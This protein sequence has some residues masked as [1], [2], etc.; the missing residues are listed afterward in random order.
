MIVN[1]DLS[2]TLQFGVRLKDAQRKLVYIFPNTG[3][4]MSSGPG[5][6]GIEPGAGALLLVA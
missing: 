3:K 5:M 2:R 4:E 6:D 1:R